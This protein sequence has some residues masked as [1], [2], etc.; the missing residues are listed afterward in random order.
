M[1]LAMLT[2]DDNSKCKFYKINIYAHIQFYDIKLL[3]F[4]VHIFLLQNER[5]TEMFVKYCHEE[6]IRLVRRRGGGETSRL[7]AYNTDDVAEVNCE[8]FV[9]IITRQKIFRK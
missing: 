9:K 3:L 8:H 4:I 2:R 7:T 6:E 5:K 1:T